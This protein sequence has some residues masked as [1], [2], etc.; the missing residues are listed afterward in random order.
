[1]PAEQ[2]LP[3]LEWLIVDDHLALSGALNHLI[4]TAERQTAAR[5]RPNARVPSQA[6]NAGT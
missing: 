1:M 4:S 5:A 3:L 6:H 2:K